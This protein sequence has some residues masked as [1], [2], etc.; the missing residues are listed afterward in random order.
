VNSE[1][2][3]SEQM[4]LDKSSQSNQIRKEKKIV[5]GRARTCKIIGKSIIEVF[6]DDKKI[7]IPY[8]EFI[9]EFGVKEKIEKELY[10]EI[11]DT[12]LC[13]NNDNVNN[14]NVNNDKYKE[15]RI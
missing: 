5:C 15:S 2:V 9:S 11:Y 3:S 14:D 1:K 8:N 12:Y 10:E 7:F 13:V 6:D 4:S